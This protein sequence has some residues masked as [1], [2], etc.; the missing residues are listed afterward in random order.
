MPVMIS[1]AD[2]LCFFALLF[3][4]FL[5]FSS[6]SLLIFSI[7]SLLCFEPFLTA[8]SRHSISY[9]VGPWFPLHDLLCGELPSQV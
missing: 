9:G 6:S 2:F 3:D 1:L 7:F 4:L 5:V 8:V